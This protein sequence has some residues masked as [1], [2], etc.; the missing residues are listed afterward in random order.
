MAALM[1]VLC[2]RIDSST[3]NPTLEA[4]IDL[5]L[6]L[7]TRDQHDGNY[8]K[9]THRSRRQIRC[10]PERATRKPAPMSSFTITVVDDAVKKELEKLKGKVTNLSP[11]LRLIGEGIIERTKRRFETSTSPNGTPWK[12]NSA[13]TLDLFEIRIGSSKRKKD[14]SLNAAG[15]RMLANKKPLIGDT[16]DLSR[17]FVSTV[18]SNSLTISSTPIYAAIQQFGGRAGRGHKVTIPARPF[19]PIYQGGT[20]YAQEQKLVLQA[21]NDYLLDRQ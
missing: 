16:F 10:M 5:R 17:Q 9:D 3:S 6:D 21:I 11:V 14:G 8:H 15:K 18:Q 7:F 13:A 2:D 1:R 12:P 4:V 20:L 19:L